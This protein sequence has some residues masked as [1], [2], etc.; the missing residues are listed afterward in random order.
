MDQNRGKL[1]PVTTEQLLEWVRD[2]RS[3]ERFYEKAGD[4]LPNVTTSAYLAELLAARGLSRREVVEA[5]NLERS[6]GYL[7]FAGKRNP[8]R[9]TLLRIAL[10]M[11]LTPDETQ[12]LLK[13]AQRGELYPKNRR[14]AA[15]LFCIHHGMRLLDAELLLEEIGEPQLQ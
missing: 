13:I 4:N 5:A 11:Q 2:A 12:R 15:I 14:D 1:S 6:S 3:L 8:K 10:V 7:I 9:D